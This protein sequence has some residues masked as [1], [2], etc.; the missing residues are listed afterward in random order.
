MELFLLLAA[1]RALDNQTYSCTS[2]RATGK[3]SAKAFRDYIVFFNEEFGNGKRLFGV[4]S[5]ALMQVPGRIAYISHTEIYK[6][7]VI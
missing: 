1:F 2:C 4:F 6:L 7:H 3:I 5:C